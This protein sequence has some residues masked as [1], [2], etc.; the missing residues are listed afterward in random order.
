MS[1]QI[2]PIDNK[3][4]EQLD[5][6]MRHLVELICEADCYGKHVVDNPYHP[7]EPEHEWYKEKAN[8]LGTAVL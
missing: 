6:N 2:I 7:G 5:A 1:A 3:L 8:A 4:R